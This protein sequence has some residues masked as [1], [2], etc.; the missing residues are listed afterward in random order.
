[1][2]WSTVL[3]VSRSFVQPAEQSTS[4]PKISRHLRETLRRKCRW[5]LKWCSA[6]RGEFFFGGREILVI[7][8]S[9]L[10][11]WVPQLGEYLVVEK[12]A[13]LKK[14][15]LCASQRRCFRLSQ[16]VS[17]QSAM[18]RHLPPPNPRSFPKRRSAALPYFLPTAKQRR[19]F[20]PWK[21]TKAM[22]QIP[23]KF[24]IMRYYSLRFACLVVATSS[25][26][27]S[28][29]VV[30]LWFTTVESVKITKKETTVT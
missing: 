16:K 6:L 30:Y 27:L 21:S 5:N 20:R 18:P 3:I 11:G 8:A 4:T 24:G 29:M 10:G 1:M 23:W 2:P 14:Y 12:K 17:Y 22:E 25:K 19:K 7:R 26:K 13:A 28:P 9:F 15:A